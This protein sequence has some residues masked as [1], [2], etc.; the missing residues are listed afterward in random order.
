MS[1][2]AQQL[3]DTLF[4]YTA[5][6]ALLKQVRKQRHL[7]TGYRRLW[8]ILGRVPRPSY[9]P[10]PL[11]VSL[12]EWFMQREPKAR[13]PLYASKTMQALHYGA[14]T[15]VL[16]QKISDLYDQQGQS[17]LEGLPSVSSKDPLWQALSQ[18]RCH[19]NVY[20]A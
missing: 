3:Q 17:L 19:S 8:G 11:A 15:I 6:K 7:F 2:F 9:M 18:W 4:S 20:R 16:A 5:S 14:T 12:E 10:T 13:P 1:N